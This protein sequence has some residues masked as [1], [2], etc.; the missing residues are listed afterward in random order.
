MV[1]RDH[2]RMELPSAA[3]DCFENGAFKCLTCI[4][5]DKQLLTIIP[6]T[7]DVVDRSWE[8]NVLLTWQP[9]KMPF[10]DRKQLYILFSMFD[11]CY[12]RVSDFVF[13]IAGVQFSDSS[14]LA[15]P[16]MSSFSFRNDP[17]F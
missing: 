6:T 15:T 5:R 9:S 12:V 14:A 2:I 8:F 1:A 11:P 4:F 17:F 16:P 10:K 13:F 7:N 3:L